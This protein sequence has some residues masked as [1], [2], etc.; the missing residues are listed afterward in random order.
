MG[1]A[2]WGL[3]VAIGVAA[4]VEQPRVA[5]A[6]SAASDRHRA[7][8]PDI[9]D[10]HDPVRAG[11]APP[12]N[13]VQVLPRDAIAPIYAPTHVTAREI[14]WDH[15]TMV[16][17]VALE[18]A[19]VA[20]PVRS[21]SRR[22]IVNDWIDDTPILVSWCPLCGSAMVHRRQLDGRELVMGNQG[23]LLSGA[24]TLFDHGTGSVWS[25]ISGESVLGPLTGSRLLLVPSVL[26]HWGSWLE[27]HPDSRALDAEGGAGGILAEDTAVVVEIGEDATAFP[28]GDLREV[29]VANVRVGGVPVAVVAEAT[30]GGWW[31][32]YSRELAGRV[33][34]LERR[35]DVLA[36]VDGAGRWDAAVGRA[37]GGDASPPLRPVAGFTMFPSYFEVHVPTEPIWAQAS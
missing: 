20:Y 17:G 6:T 23:A 2:F 26:T 15:D 14:D 18:G 33:L 29:G 13:F 9:A 12:G 7:G 25:Q 1:V 19:S 32:V 3:M 31:A 16:I 28:I 11:E 21:L 35:G 5:D 22:E 4:L 27:A 24:L 10:V 34:V 37:L 8:T 36:E 30:A